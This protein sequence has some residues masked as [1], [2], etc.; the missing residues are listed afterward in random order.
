MESVRALDSD[1]DFEFGKG[2][3]NYLTNQ[4]AVVQNINTRLNSFLG[5]CFF[6]MGAGINWFNLMGQPG[7][8]AQAALNLAITNTILNTPS[9]TGLLQLNINVTSTR[10]MSVTYKVATIYSISSSVFSLNTTIG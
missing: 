9:V 6:D 8:A 5:N 10:A 4:A 1:G 7:A 2:A 3:N